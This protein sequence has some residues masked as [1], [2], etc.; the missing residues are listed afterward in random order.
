MEKSRAG[1]DKL[2]KARL[3][4]LRRQFEFLQME[5]LETISEYFTKVSS[6]TNSMK[7]C[8]YKISDLKTIEKVMFILTPKFDY[9]VVIIERI[10]KP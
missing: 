9:I 10:Q 5:N 8:A 2:K 7:R 3:Q 1:G 4:T 6:L